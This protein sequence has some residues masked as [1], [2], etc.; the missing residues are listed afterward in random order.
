MALLKGFP[1]LFEEFEGVGK[2]RHK[3]GEVREVK[4]WD[5]IKSN[6]L[7]GKHVGMWPTKVEHSGKMSLEQLLAQSNQSETE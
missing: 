4:F 2:E 5:K 1:E 3:I 7:V 6:E